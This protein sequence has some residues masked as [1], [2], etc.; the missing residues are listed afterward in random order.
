MAI[1]QKQIPAINPSFKPVIHPP[2]PM[3]VINSARPIV[4]IN[5]VINEEIKIPANPFLALGS[6]I[7]APDAFIQA[8]LNKAEY[9]IAPRKK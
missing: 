8:S 7:F 1:A 4:A 5:I 9:Q 3:R 2:A 6:F